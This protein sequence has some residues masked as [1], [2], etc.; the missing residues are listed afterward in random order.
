MLFSIPLMSNYRLHNNI[1]NNKNIVLL[2]D[3]LCA[4]CL[5][6]FC[7][8]CFLFF[9]CVN[10]WCKMRA[11]SI[12]CVCCVLHIFTSV[13][14]YIL[15][16]VLFTVEK[17]QNQHSACCVYLIFFLKSRE[18]S[19]E[20]LRLQFLSSINIEYFFYKNNIRRD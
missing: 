12:F 5:S 7:F 11:C 3:F 16:F 17:L 8:F 10:Q 2:F 20:I 4:F 18:V 9:T 13:Y 14:T 1:R 15:F 6:V 19:F